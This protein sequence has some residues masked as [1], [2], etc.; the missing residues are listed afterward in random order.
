MTRG[1]TALRWAVR[2]FC[3]AAVA[4]CL[5]II[6]SAFFLGRVAAWEITVWAAVTGLTFGWI[7]PALDRR[8]RAWERTAQGWKDSAAAYAKMLDDAHEDNVRLLRAD[9]RDQL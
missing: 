4:G 1:D 6:A 5:L 3:P 7:I 9:R 2:I 8:A